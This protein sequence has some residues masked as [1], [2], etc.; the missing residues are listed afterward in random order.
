[1]A[2]VGYRHFSFGLLGAP[3]S[4]L[5]IRHRTVGDGMPALLH[6]VVLEAKLIAFS[7]KGGPA[8][9][10]GWEGDIETPICS[11]LGICLGW[12]TA[13]GTAGVASPK[14]S[15]TTRIPVG[16]RQRGFTKSFPRS[17]CGCWHAPPFL[18]K[19]PFSRER[20]PFYI[21]LA[22]Y[23]PPG[24]FSRSAYFVRPGESVQDYLTLNP[25]Y[26]ISCLFKSKEEVFKG[27]QWIN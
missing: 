15:V 10:S 20:N 6:L 19:H 27:E 5:C 11:K 24:E 16:K 14:Y 1:M 17:E 12:G 25:V 18:G 23:N 22:S 8:Q 2:A 4:R 7:P 26:P 21:L 3:L 9:C 13:L